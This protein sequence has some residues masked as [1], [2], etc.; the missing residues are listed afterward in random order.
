MGSG[1]K[2]F[3]TAMTRDRGVVS[4]SDG[5]DVS[6][7]IHVAR[8]TI[9][10]FHPMNRWLSVPEIFMYSSNIGTVH[11]VMDAGTPVQQDFLGQLGLLQPAAVE[12]SEVGAPLVPSPW[13]EIN[14]MTISYGHG[15]AVSTL[16]LTAAMA[17]LL[18]GGSAD[19]PTLLLPQPAH[20]PHGDHAISAPT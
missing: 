17:S 18:N 14:T 4:L 12:L 3:S 1:V 11:M 10:D 7:P 9:R 13:R 20:T 6:E 8:Y 5:Y 16:Q 19:S 15:L 2:I